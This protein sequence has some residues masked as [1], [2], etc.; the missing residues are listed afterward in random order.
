VI[1]SLFT[2]QRRQS[3]TVCDFGDRNISLAFS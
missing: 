2:E 3:S 1:Y